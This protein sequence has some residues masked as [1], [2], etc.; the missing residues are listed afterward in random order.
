MESKQYG[1]ELIMLKE[2]EQYNGWSNYETW[3]VALWIGGDEGLYSIAKECRNEHNP[4][5]AF[6][7]IIQESRNEKQTNGLSYQTPDGVAWSDSGINKDEVNEYIR[8]L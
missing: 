3:N 2:E 6:V 8:E 7:E 1:K 5:Q 4:Y